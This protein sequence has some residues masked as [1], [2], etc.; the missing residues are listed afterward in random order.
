TITYDL[1]IDRRPAGGSLPN[2]SDMGH[3]D[4][5]DA[6]MDTVAETMA[7]LKSTMERRNDL[8]AVKDVEAVKDLEAV[9]GLEDRDLS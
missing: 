1:L 4:M 9:K 6:D 2:G 3:A 8:R 7:Q 5:R